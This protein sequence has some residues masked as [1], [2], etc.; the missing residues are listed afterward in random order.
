MTK[1]M[2]VMAKWSSIRK[3]RYAYFHC[4]VNANCVEL[5]GG[6]WLGR[7]DKDSPYAVLLVVQSNQI[8]MS[9]A[10]SVVAVN[11]LKN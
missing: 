4:N 7:N 8:A 6:R 11:L 2:R 5:L 9:D 10:R 1:G 3:I